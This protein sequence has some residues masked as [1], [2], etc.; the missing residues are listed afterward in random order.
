MPGYGQFHLPTREIRDRG[1]PSF[2][3]AIQRRQAFPKQQ[4]TGPQSARFLI[5]N[6]QI[7]VG[8]GRWPRLQA[9][10]AAT[11]IQGEIL[12]HETVRANDLPGTVVLKEETLT[13]LQLGRQQGTADEAHMIV[14]ESG[15]AQDM[16][17]VNVSVDY[18]ADGEC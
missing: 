5:N 16:I 10:S 8:M 11:Q 3:T 9:Q 4:I 12:F 7:A 6:S 2:R 17:E 18:V 13:A 14:R 1:E 15:V